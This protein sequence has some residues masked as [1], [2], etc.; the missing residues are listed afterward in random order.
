M[1][2]EGQKKV[3]ETRRRTSWGTCG[4]QR[5]EVK[6]TQSWLQE[7]KFVKP[8]EHHGTVAKLTS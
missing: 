8:G 5:Q 6:K 1:F 4:G 2:Q 7:A 3:E